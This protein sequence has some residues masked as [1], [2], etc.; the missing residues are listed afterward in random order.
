MSFRSPQA[1]EERRQVGEI[2]FSGSGLVRDIITALVV[3]SCNI[4]RIFW[5]YF[6]FEL[7]FP[8][9]IDHKMNSL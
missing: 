3:F 5:I 8:I 1:S 2:L 7:V 9:G 4:I 6:D